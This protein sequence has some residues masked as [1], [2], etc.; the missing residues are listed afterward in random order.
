MT[1]SLNYSLT[2]NLKSRDASTSKNEGLRISNVTFPMS[3]KGYTNT[4]I[5]RYTNTQLQSA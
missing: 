1:Y 5:H 2:D 3:N 4:Y